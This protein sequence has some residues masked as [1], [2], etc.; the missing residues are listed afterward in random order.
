M[1][2]IKP[3]LGVLFGHG[4]PPVLG[5]RRVAGNVDSWTTLP[6]PGW[7]MVGVMHWRSRRDVM[8]LAVRP[9]FP[10]ARA[11]KFAAEAATFSF[12]PHV[13]SGRALEPQ[14]SV[15]R[16]LALSSALVQLTILGR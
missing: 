5:S 1:P 13:V 4:G 8:K 16:V 11:F 2:Q 15:A 14:S 7:T 9:R 10:R 3:S 6:D 12:T